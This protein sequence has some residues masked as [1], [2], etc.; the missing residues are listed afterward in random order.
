LVKADHYLH[1]RF[2][3]SAPNMPELF[4]QHSAHDQIRLVSIMDHTPGQRQ[5]VNLDK[6]KARI[7]K[8]LEYDDDQIDALIEMRKGD[9]AQYAVEH[10]TAVI[11][12]AKKRGIA[13]ASHDD[14]TREHAASAARKGVS[15]SEFPTTLDAAETAKAEGMLTVMGAPNLIL[16][17]S[18][19]GNVAA[20]ELVSDGLL[21]ILSSDYL[22]AS[23]LEGAWMLHTNFELPLPESI[24]T[25]TASSA[26]A[27]G[28]T[29]RG[30][31]AVSKRA[32]FVRVSIVDG[33]PV[34]RSVWREGIRIA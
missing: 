21:D 9:Q 6:Y 23:L 20:A 22:P 13:I 17:K 32:D 14:T 12:W 33:L 11:T 27:V 26:A 4:Q 19:S 16:G 2:E 1:L 30:I 8:R 24:A 15:I 5:W 34:V 25:V 28:F 10:E 18:H 29:D 7:R 31:I 3:I